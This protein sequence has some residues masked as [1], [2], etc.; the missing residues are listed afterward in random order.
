MHIQKSK[1]VC[2]R[3]LTGVICAIIFILTCHDADAGRRRWIAKDYVLAVHAGE[4]K[5]GTYPQDYLERLADEM[6]K[7]LKACPGFRVVERKELK[8]RTEQCLAGRSDL[9]IRQKC[10][11]LA[12]SELKAQ[13]GFAINIEKQR[14][15]VCRLNVVLFD[16]LSGA[17]N[18]W[19]GDTSACE[20][21][22]FVR[23]I[24]KAVEKVAG[25]Q[26][27][28]SVNE[29]IGKTDA[30]I[31]ISLAQMLERDKKLQE[32]MKHLRR[33]SEMSPSWKLPLVMQAELAQKMGD[34]ELSQSIYRRLLK[35]VKNDLIFREL[36]R[37]KL[38]KIGPA[39]IKEPEKQ[40]KVN[41]WIVLGLPI[42][43]HAMA[44][45][46]VDDGSVLVV[47]T[48][49]R[50]KEIDQ[51]WVEKLGFKGETYGQMLLM[52]FR[53]GVL[54]WAVRSEKA[55]GSRR[56]SFGRPLVESLPG[57]ASLVG[58]V[59]HDSV[60]LGGGTTDK[61]SLS[62]NEDGVAFVAKYDPG[63]KLAWVWRSNNQGIT[64]VKDIAAMPDGGCLIAGW[65]RGGMSVAGEKFA[66]K[67]DWTEL[68]VV[69]LDKD[70]APVW[71]KVVP[72]DGVWSLGPTV[73]PIK[74]DVYKDGSSVLMVTL[75]KDCIMN[76]TRG[77]RTK[78]LHLYRFGPDGKQ[79]WS[80][81]F[82]GDWLEG[83][84]VAA[85]PGGSLLLTGNFKKPFSLKGGRNLVPDKRTDAFVVRLNTEGT[86][87]WGYRLGGESYDY[88]NY[89]ESLADGA[90]TWSGGFSE[91]ASKGGTQVE[92]KMLKNKK[93]YDVLVQGFDV[94]GRPLW[95]CQCDAGDGPAT[96]TDMSADKKGRVA[97][98]GY[99]ARS[100]SLRVDC[101]RDLEKEVRGMG[102][103][104]MGINPVAK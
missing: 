52:K 74:V 51:A 70:G 97:I 79:T 100:D 94:T 55:T 17:N 48:A 1:N 46:A 16:Q 64:V 19:Y 91:N 3:V 72:H 63:G 11:L 35:S 7:K 29:R 87:E 93:S 61:A 18:R 89:V 54:E 23:V 65:V 85:L 53:K 42:Q 73:A 84:D 47:G 41:L 45:S 37:R 58:G 86:A 82:D 69:R 14:G 99:N 60:V 25:E 68:F 8:K 77:R 66:S 88:G 21:D 38:L 6:Q 49:G 92:G 15:L 9:R 33:A 43:R 22:D 56:G 96:A 80:K 28:T 83:R 75:E 34:V 12:G 40:G 13:K 10:R 4:E 71:A 26:S 36:V 31:E 44:V 57:G 32:A 90:F 30:E 50:R 76:M 62:T 20:F 67:G 39:A 5:S 102:V 78:R 104:V 2:F 81:R 98:I 103:F 24:D 59:F 95:W 101:G 27:D